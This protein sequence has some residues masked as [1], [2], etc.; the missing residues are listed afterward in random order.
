LSGPGRFAS[1]RLLEWSSG[2]ISVSELDVGGTMNIEGDDDKFLNPVLLVNAADAAGTDARTIALTM[3]TFQNNRRVDIQGC[4]TTSAD[5]ISS[6]QNVNGLVTKAAGD[7]TT[8][9]L[10]FV[11]SGVL[12]LNGNDITLSKG[13]TQTGGGSLTDLGGG[14]LG[15]SGYGFTLNGGL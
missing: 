5:P 7:T 10:T 12:L 13:T 6:F 1:Q 3:S 9:D 14:T 15:V 2:T 11:Q 4:A 8:F